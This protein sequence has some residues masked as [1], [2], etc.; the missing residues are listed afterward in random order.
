[1]FRLSYDTDS[2]VFVAVSKTLYP[3]AFIPDRL[4]QVLHN[5]LG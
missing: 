5:I 4:C 3:I 2:V 1:M